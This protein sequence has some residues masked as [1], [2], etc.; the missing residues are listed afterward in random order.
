MELEAGFGHPIL[1]HNLSALFTVVVAPRR[2]D[3][4]RLPSGVGPSARGRYVLH[5]DVWGDLGEISKYEVASSGVY[6]GV[7]RRFIRERAR[8]TQNLYVCH[9]GFL[10]S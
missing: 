7:L 9:T 6:S 3:E 5:G 8:I 2:H 1:Y 4:A 10:V